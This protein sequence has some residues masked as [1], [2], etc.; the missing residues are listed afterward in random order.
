M[1]SPSKFNLCLLN[2]EVQLAP[3]FVVKLCVF[4]G[5]FWVDALATDMLEDG[6]IIV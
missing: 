5:N 2:L 1:L 4:I 3:L 6:D